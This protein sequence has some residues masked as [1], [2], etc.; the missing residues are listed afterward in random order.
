MVYL[1]GVDS[2]LWLFYASREK[3]ISIQVNPWM[4]NKGKCIVDCPCTIYCNKIIS[5]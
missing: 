2:C 1:S 4:V 5:Y 3:L